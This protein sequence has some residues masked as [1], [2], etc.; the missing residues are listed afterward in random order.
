[1]SEAK[2]TP[3]PLEIVGATRL[4]ILD[5]PGGAVCIIANP[6]CPTSADFQEVR[7]KDARWKEAMANADRLM[8]CWNSHD[9]L[10]A[11][12]GN[13]VSL[14][15]TLEGTYENKDGQITAQRKETEAALAQAKKLPT[16]LAIRNNQK[17]NKDGNY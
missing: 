3:G 7:L 16:I 8:L 2:H 9:A 5:E 1:M 15:E 4:W 14:L 17:D 6:D 11:A 12:C 13:C 10:V